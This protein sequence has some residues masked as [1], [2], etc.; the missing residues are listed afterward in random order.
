MGSR[1]SNINKWEWVFQQ[2]ILAASCSQW[3][4]SPPDLCVLTLSAPDGQHGVDLPDEVSQLVHDLFKL[5]VL[6]LELLQGNT[7]NEERRRETKAFHFVPTGLSYW[8]EPRVETFDH[9]LTQ[10]NFC[11]VGWTDVQPWAEE[12]ISVHCSRPF[13]PIYSTTLRR[14]TASRCSDHSNSSSAWPLPG[15]LIHIYLLCYSDNLQKCWSTSERLHFFTI[16]NKPKRC[17]ACGLFLSN[18]GDVKSDP[19]L[20]GLRGYSWCFSCEDLVS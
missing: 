17:Y 2:N 9:P 5:L 10:L 4:P 13:K 16:N 11:H 7:R 3:R 8:F 18:Q 14:I 12:H 15:Q 1:S 20:A 19:S 6:L